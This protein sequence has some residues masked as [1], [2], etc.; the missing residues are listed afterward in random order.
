MR[1][2]ELG[3][4]GLLRELERRGLA[5][6]IGDDAAVFGDGFVVT[7]DALA[8]GVH[9]RLETT[10]WRDL[11]YKAAAVNLSDLA[12]MGAEPAG[13]LV[14]LTVPDVRVED[15]L[16]LYRG[17][18]EPGFAVVG[19][20]TTQAERV[21]VAVTAVGESARVPGRAGAKPGDFLV[22]TGPLGGSAAGLR[23]LEQ[24]L[25]G[26]DDLVERHRRPPY[27]LDA[28]RRLAPT[29][30][31]LLDLSDGIASDAE[32]IAERSSCRL[33]IDVDAVPRAPRIEE[34]GDDPFWT[35]GEDY[36]LLAALAPDDPVQEDFTVVGRC[37]AGEGVELRRD[38]ELL[39]LAGWDHFR[40]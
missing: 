11:G 15:V 24:G 28:A 6:G 39:E 4:F 17:L 16:D 38:G 13:L 14:S 21:T 34:V 29:A 35:L 12:A 3:E 1:L 32:R 20:D 26:F 37:E 22:V 7:Q 25:D 30:H 19:G 40:V 2:S 8:E 23:A 36:E 18:T 10:S 27:R 9:F 33:V 31:A 5:H